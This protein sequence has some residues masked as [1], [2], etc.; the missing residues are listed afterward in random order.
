MFQIPLQ[1]PVDSACLWQ[2]S[3]ITHVRCD[4]M[5]ISMSKGAQSTFYKNFRIT[6][7]KETKNITDNNVIT[8]YFSSGFFFQYKIYQVL[9]TE[10]M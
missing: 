3:G 5:S 10:I 9:I 2:T 6:T 4:T 1:T 8:L 7:R